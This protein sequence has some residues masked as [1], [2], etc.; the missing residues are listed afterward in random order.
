MRFASLGS[1]SR[2]NATLISQGKTTLLVDC[3]FSARETEKRLQGFGL[4]ASELSAIVVTHEHADH[5]NGVRVLARKYQLPVYA[6][7][8]T[9]GCMSADLVELITEFSCHD[10]FE[11]GDIE[12]HP[13][14]VPHD[15]RE[16]SQFVFTNGQHRLGLLTDVGTVTPVIEQ[17]LSQCD[18]L[19]L[20]ANHDID[21]LDN[22]DY[23]DHLKYRVAGRLGHLNNVQ[24]AT[25]LEKIDT[26]HLQHIVA[27]HLSEKN[28]SPDIVSPLFAQA[29]QCEQSWIS[30]AKQ[31]TGFDWRETIN[32]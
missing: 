11:I 29:L 8:G 10:V 2:G 28:N 13:F 17:A 32:G 16:P 18:A 12:V 7:A 25:L 30:I 4:D 14:P 1:G 31:D 15:A 23:P 6:T 21:M 20:E 9:A 26:T 3:G 27:M 5:V 19:L 24:S 22:G